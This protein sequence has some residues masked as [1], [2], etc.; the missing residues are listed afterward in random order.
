LIYIKRVFTIMRK[1]SWHIFQILTKRS[2]RLVEIAPKLTWHDNVW[3]GVT[4]ENSDY[5]HR[6]DDLRK[7]PSSIRFL[8][9]EPLLGPLRDLNLSGMDWVIVGGESG[10]S[11][12][13][14]KE[15]WIR[16]IR[17]QCKRNDVPFF[18]KQWGG[19]NKKKAGRLLNG[20]LYSGMPS[21]ADNQLDLI[22]YR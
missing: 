5:I 1:A 16:D 12:R 7:I 15:E 4:V 13:P 21:I 6:I 11:A 9:F 2:E 10:P 18:F 17:R 19:Q 8:S 14:M 20:K 3:M 22:A